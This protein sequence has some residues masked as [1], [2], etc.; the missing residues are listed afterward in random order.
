M[1]LTNKL[2]LSISHPSRSRN[3]L[4]GRNSFLLEDIL[5]FQVCV[6]ENNIGR[7]G[8]KKKFI[9]FVHCTEICAILK[10]IQSLLLFND[11]VSYTAHFFS[12]DVK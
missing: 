7:G 9:F 10:H 5:R 1:A 8:G 3:V 4:I 11:T 12:Y 2:F 6:Q